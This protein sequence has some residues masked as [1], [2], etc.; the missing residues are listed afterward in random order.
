MKTIAV[1]GAG[2]CGLALTWELLQKGHCV[3]LYD[4]AGVGGG[5]S[6][7]SAGLLHPF[8]GIH[9]KLAESGR[10][11]LEATYELLNIASS[12]LEKPVFERTGMLRLA[13][14]VEMVDDFQQCAKL[15]DDVTWMR[16]QECQEK[17][18]GLEPL[19]GIW[20]ES[21]LTVRSLP[22]LQGLWKACEL[23]GATLF[24][25]K[26]AS[27]NA[28]AHYDGTVIATGAAAGELCNLSVTKVK[29]QVLELEWPADLP[30]LPVP[31]NS[32]AY[33]LMQPGN[34]SCLAGATYERHFLTENPDSEVALRDILPKVTALLPGLQRSKLLSC[35]A[36]LRASTPCHKP[37]MKQI[38]HKTWVLTGMGSK[39]LLYHALFAK[40]ISKI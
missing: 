29:G 38:D 5:A 14:T 1:V 28:I 10:E 16:A 23:L 17:V 35:R 34:R 24:Q 26:I 39:G 32:H 30:P 3:H 9:A 12:A 4:S 6:G 20:I 15:Y 11:G 19:P 27:L 18:P 7:I 31:L 37:L 21:A 13:A 33:I 8:F 22:Y 40:K 36:G 2:F 25:Q